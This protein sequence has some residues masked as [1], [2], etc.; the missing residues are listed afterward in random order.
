M[1]KLATPISHFFD[2][3]SR[4]EKIVAESSCLECREK[5]L[6][7]TVPNQ[8]LFHLDTDIN[9]PWGSAEKEFLSSIIRNKKDLKLITFHMSTSCTEPILREEVYYCEGKTLSRRE[10]LDNIKENM[11]WFR[12]QIK[13]RE[14]KI[15]VE[16]NN[17]YPTG[18][19]EDVTD[20]DFLQQSVHGNNI[21]FVFD[22][23]H[24][25][26]TAF[27]KKISLDEYMKEL[28]FDRLIQVHVSKEGFNDKGWAM[29][30]H[31]LPD[32]GMYEEVKNLLHYHS[33]EYLTI[34]YY[35][36]YDKLIELLKKY[37]NL[38]V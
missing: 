13:G 1:V 35:K 29:D 24:A 37:H 34:E 11:E 3:K 19:Y 36:D 8:Y 17:Y 33:P 18:A 30:A 20:A 31:E 25:K 15:G 7:S 27:N 23:A 22:I 26:I 21:Y 38:C 16:N 4:G 28:P 5:S 10:M 9:R 32:S 6:E 14:I 12:S 2:D